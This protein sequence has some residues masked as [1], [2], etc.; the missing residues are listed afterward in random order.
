MTQKVKG[1]TGELLR[2][3]LGARN[4]IL[5]QMEDPGEHFSWTPPEGGKSAAE[6]AEHVASTVDLFCAMIADQL[7]VEIDLH[8][9]ETEGNQDEV[10]RGQIRSAYE[11]FKDLCG[12]LDDKLLEETVTLPPQTGFREG[13]VETVL[14]VIAGFHAVHHAGQIVMLLKRAERSK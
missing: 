13:P 7:N 10:A 1:R 12:K 8:E 3:G 9:A 14:R 2:F 11:G 5:G 6:I 4:W